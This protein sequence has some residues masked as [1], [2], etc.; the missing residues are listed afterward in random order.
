VQ[1]QK[2]YDLV[3]RLQDEGWRS[4]K[5]RLER[6]GRQRMRIRDEEGV[7][8]L[9]FN[10]HIKTCLHDRSTWVREIRYLALRVRRISRSKAELYTTAKATRRPW[11]RSRMPILKYAPAWTRD[12][13]ISIAPHALSR[14]IY[15]VF[16]TIF[17]QD[18]I[19][20]VI[21]MIIIA[22][23][24]VKQLLPLSRFLIHLVSR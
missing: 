10:L 21:I 17:A 6:N 14:S 8:Y 24:D 19:T 3:L 4:C 7:L 1:R 13:R 20:I 23:W 5:M 12:C 9:H 16:G 11:N 2:R 18:T 15:A 22:S